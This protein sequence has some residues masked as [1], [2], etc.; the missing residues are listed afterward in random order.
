MIVNLLARLA[1]IA[2]PE[3]DP[4]RRAIR[5]SLFPLAVFY[6]LFSGTI[7]LAL[8]FIRAP[9]GGPHGLVFLF[10]WLESSALICVAAI[11]ATPQPRIG[12]Y[13]PWFLLA[14]A[15][16]LGAGILTFLSWLVI[17]PAVALALLVFAGAA[18][19]N[20]AG[21]PAIIATLAS[22]PLAACYFFQINSMMYDSVFLPEQILAGGAYPDTLFHTALASIIAWHGRVASALDGLVP[23]RYH[24]FSHLWFGLTAKAA[25]INVVN[26]YYLGMQV[27][28]LPLLLFGLGFATLALTPARQPAPAAALLIAVP[29]ALL[30]TIDRYDWMSY[31]AS[32][33]YMV[34]LLLFLIGLPYLR[35]LSS[36]DSYATRDLVSGLLYGLL[37]TTAKISIGAVWTV[38]FLYIVARSRSLS[39]P[40]Y[41]ALCAF[42]AIQ[43]YVVLAVTL[44]NDN[45]S[46]TTVALLHYVRSYPIVA[47]ANL[48]PIGIAAALAGRD[49]RRHGHDRWSEVVL[50]ICLVT[51]LPALLLRI[52]G[53]S[54][55]YFIN[56]GTWLAVASLSG[57]IIAWT[58]PRH[59]TAV[60][61]ISIVWIVAAIALNPEKSRAYARLKQQRDALYHRLDPTGD[62]AISGRS[63]FDREALR[64]LASKSAHS[65]GADIGALL[66]N[67]RVTA[68]TNAIVMVAPEFHDYWAL[69]SQ[70]NAAPLLI[71]AYYGLPLLKGLPPL[72]EACDLGNYYGYS[73]YGATSHAA[74]IDDSTLCSLARDKGFDILVILRSRRVADRLDCTKR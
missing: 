35:S 49:L 66:R 54:A 48:V 7:A 58:R 29:L 10:Y 52:E 33:S 25:G 50:L 45:V 61:A 36:N 56:I 27:L 55:Y 72:M 17:I 44:P 42:L 19:V 24:V 62:A 60:L 69:T 63:L 38:S 12:P 26:G 6:L 14:M 15:I 39:K 8:Y 51:A 74:N 68:D 28:G 41:A 21:L 16:F 37:L 31:L 13:L 70:C 43:V 34:G 32:E 1:S 59:F 57:R 20:R 23:I 4:S 22:L 46:S 9:L 47:F 2:H 71:P 40:H 30:C 53:G 3:T 5:E 64:A 67:A 18:H 11:A 73:L 65:T